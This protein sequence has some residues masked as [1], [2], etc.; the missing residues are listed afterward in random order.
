MFLRF[1]QSIIRIILA[2]TAAVLILCVGITVA[3]AYVFQS[4]TE[5]LYEAVIFGRILPD[6]QQMPQRIGA[7]EEKAIASGEAEVAMATLQR[8]KGLGKLTGDDTWPADSFRDHVGDRRI[9]G[10]LSKP[11]SLFFL[12]GDDNKTLILYQGIH[13][14]DGTF[15]SVRALQIAVPDANAAVSSLDGFRTAESSRLDERRAK[16]A[17]L[18]IALGRV[19]AT[20]GKTIDEVTAS[21]RVIGDVRSRGLIWGAVVLAALLSGGLVALT[22]ILRRQ[23]RIIVSLGRAVSEITAARDDPDRLAR[24]EIPG[25]ERIDETGL[26]A[27]GLQAARDALIETDTLRAVQERQRE[28]AEQEKRDALSTMAE[29]IE[30]ETRRE[31]EEVLA[32]TAQMADDAGSMVRSA[33]SVDAHSQDVA[34]AAAQALA[35]AQSVASAAEQL[36]ASINGITHQIGSA[37]QVAEKAV[38]A[39]GRAQ[40]TIGQLSSAVDRIGEV[41]HL[42]NGIAAQTNLLALNATIEAARAGDAGKGFAVVANEVKQLASQT[43]RATEE[44][45]RQIAEIQTTTARAVGAVTEIGA[46]ITEVQEMSAT[47]A[48]SV[49]QQGVATAEIA[50]NVVETTLAAQAVSDRI[51]RVSDEASV[52]RHSAG[53]VNELSAKVASGVDQMRE[54]LVQAVNASMDKVGCQQV[55]QR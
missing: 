30:A 27:A 48:E 39:S 18:Q 43:A 41:A 37:G 49:E 3:T 53:H 14:P 8:A 12:A 9:R 10:G 34:A 38:G 21:R 23:A 22:A 31:V 2:S 11:G 36:S 24:I 26:L 19:Q 7:E 32:L 51:S 45:S 16:F 25:R 13:Q 1:R 50:R 5:S 42:I 46:A 47:V 44:I 6:I 29:T 4:R 17:D 40:S 28:N 20:V 54:V 33:T 35:N 52:T 15:L 55:L